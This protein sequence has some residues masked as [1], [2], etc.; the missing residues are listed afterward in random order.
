V[1]ATTTDTGLSYATRSS[2]LCRW[3][4]E[5]TFFSLATTVPSGSCAITHMHGQRVG[6]CGML[7]TIGM[8]GLSLISCAFSP[9]LMLR[10]ASLHC[11]CRPAWNAHND[12][13]P[14]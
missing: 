3:Q 2:L 14:T 13:G 11:A 5:Y 12:R 6:I 10:L 9:M 8:A 7:A 1:P 4:A